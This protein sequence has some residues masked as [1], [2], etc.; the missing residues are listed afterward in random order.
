MIVILS[1][2]GDCKSGLPKDRVDCGYG[3]IPAQD[4]LA[5]GCCFD[6]SIPDV[7]WCFKDPSPSNFTTTT[8]APT[9]A[10]CTRLVRPK[11]EHYR[12]AFC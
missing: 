10:P 1:T 11:C 3:G 8:A 12:A 6:D 5:K 7:I 4:C 9:A 2:E